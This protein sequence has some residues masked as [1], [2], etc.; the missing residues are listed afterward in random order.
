[1]RGTILLELLQTQIATPFNVPPELQEWYKQHDGSIV[2]EDIVKGYG[3]FRDNYKTTEWDILADQLVLEDEI[4]LNAHNAFAHVPNRDEV[5]AD[6]LFLVHDPPPYEVF[7]RESVK[8]VLTLH[9]GDLG[10]S[11][12]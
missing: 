10:L 11:I 1:M 7:K 12:Q 9:V 2:F 8:R 6:I 4:L 3:L 5:A